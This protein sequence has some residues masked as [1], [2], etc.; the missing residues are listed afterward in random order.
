MVPRKPNRMNSEV[1]CDLAEV[2][3]GLPSMG[4]ENGWGDGRHLEKLGDL[5]DDYN[6]YRGSSSQPK[7]YFSP[8]GILVYIPQP[9]SCFHG[10][11]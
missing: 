1:G 6:V 7:F 11:C 8:H 3:F 2:I 9:P 4:H 5:R 10:G